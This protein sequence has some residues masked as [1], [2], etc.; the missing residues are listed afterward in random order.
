MNSQVELQKLARKAKSSQCQPTGHTLRMPLGTLR[1]WDIPVT[2]GCIAGF[3]MLN[4][5][6][7]KSRP[8]NESLLCN[9]TVIGD[10][11]SPI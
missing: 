1:K 7:K 2:F 9:G 3:H 10:D 4:C 5:R 8:S 11:Y 6:Y